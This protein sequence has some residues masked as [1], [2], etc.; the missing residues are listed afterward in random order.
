MNKKNNEKKEKIISCCNTCKFY[1]SEPYLEYNGKIAICR[2]NNSMYYKVGLFSVSCNFY[3][4]K[5][6]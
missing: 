1:D 2:C 4:K 3:K 5:E 6:K